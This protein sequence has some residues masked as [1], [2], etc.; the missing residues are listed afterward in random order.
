[1]SDGTD[2]TDGADGS[3]GTDGADGT[4]GTD[5]ADG[6]DGTDGDSK[7]FN[8]VNGLP[9]PVEKEECVNYVSKK[10]GTVLVKVNP[11]LGGYCGGKL[12]EGYH[13]GFEALL[14]QCCRSHL[15]FLFLFYLIMHLHFV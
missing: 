5:G 10:L 8:A 7:A 12:T 15:L 2:G 11:A 9:Y 3:D 14:W 13:Q 6:A 1:M 4:G